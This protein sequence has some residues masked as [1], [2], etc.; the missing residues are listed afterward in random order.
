[1]YLGPSF[2]CYLNK[3][4]LS[5]VLIGPPDD[6]FPV[7]S[8]EWYRS[9]LC[10]YLSWRLV[11]DV[12]YQF[13]GILTSPD[14]LLRGSRLVLCVLLSARDSCIQ[15]KAKPY[16]L[17]TRRCCDVES[18]SVTLIHRHNNVVVTA[19]VNQSS[20]LHWNEHQSSRVLQCKEKSSN[21]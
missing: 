4:R 19:A 1:M 6:L 5:Y 9:V 12:R 16:P 7:F 21:C 2:S 3:A 13:R 10:N 15:T 11:R 8:W 17:D 18:A 20:T 14:V